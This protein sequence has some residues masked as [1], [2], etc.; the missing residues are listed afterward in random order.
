M[1]TFGLVI[2]F[3]PAIGPTFRA[4]LLT[5]SAGAGCLSSLFLCSISI[6]F[7]VKYLQMSENRRARGLIFI[8]HTLNHRDRRNRIRI[9][10]CRRGSGR[11]SVPSD[12]RCDHHQ[13]D[14]HR[15]VRASAVET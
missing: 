14:Q 15:V 2:M 13:P 4:L 1:G 5:S 7:A 12:H 3:A 10:Q 9:Q 11:V 8:D 6:L